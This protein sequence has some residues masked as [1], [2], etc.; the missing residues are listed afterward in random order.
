MIGFDWLDSFYPAIQAVL[1]G[2]NPYV[3]NFHYPPW[4][5]IALTPFGALP[6]GAAIWINNLI[7]LACLVAFCHRWGATRTALA[8]ALSVPGIQLF[9]YSQIDW[10]IMLAFLVPRRY[11][12]A[13]LLM[14]PQSG[15]LVALLWVIEA[16]CEG[17]WRCALR[18]TLPSALMIV[19]SLALFPQWIGRVSPLADDPYISARWNGYSG[20]FAA[21]AGMIALA[22]HRR[23]ERLALWAALLLSP[24]AAGYSY[25]PLLAAIGTKMPRRIIVA[26]ALLSW[27]VVAIRAMYL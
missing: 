12:M 21:G 6:L 20:A 22:I 2:T 26:A 14:K 9:L 11:G 13:L 5:L 4:T 25:V 19:M 16:W 15:G 7:S 8:V 10:V 3:G 23:D 18:I 27:A 1:R 24:Y 17:D